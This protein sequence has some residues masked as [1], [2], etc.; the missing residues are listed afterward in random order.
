M[1]VFPYLVV[2]M[3]GC[4]LEQRISITFCVKLGKNATYTCAMLSK[5]Y[6]RDAIN[7]QVF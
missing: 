5:A 3:N 4:F 2:K 1:R 6:G 7:I